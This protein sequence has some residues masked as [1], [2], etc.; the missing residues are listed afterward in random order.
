MTQGCRK[1]IS[2]SWLLFNFH[3]IFDMLS[4]WWEINFLKSQH[5]TFVVSSFVLL[6]HDRRI[7]SMTK[8]L[9]LIVRS[10]K[11]FRWCAFSVRGK[12]QNTQLN[13]PTHMFDKEETFSRPCSRWSYKALACVRVHH[14]GIA[15]NFLCCI[16]VNTN[17]Y[18]SMKEIFCV[19]LLKVGDKT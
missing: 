15:G 12:I 8:Y 19:V 17:M 18:G 4:I 14:E 6:H 5:L 2:I 9:L 11:K 16:D 1:L 10:I 7:E 3:V 13:R